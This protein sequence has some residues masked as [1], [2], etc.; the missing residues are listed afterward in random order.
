MNLSEAPLGPSV[1][2]RP[3]SVTAAAKTRG[4]GVTAMADVIKCA[5]VCTH[6]V[7][8]WCCRCRGS[9]SALKKQ[10]A[11]AKPQS[12]LLVRDHYS[13]VTELLIPKNNL[14]LMV[15][16]STVKLCEKPPNRF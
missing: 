4:L 14:A 13:P 15:K 5:R 10:M 7:T 6:N 3:L 2:G 16:I 11:N 9:A 8:S 12:V 1:D